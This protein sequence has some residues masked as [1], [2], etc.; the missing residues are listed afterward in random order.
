MNCSSLGFDQGT[1][2]LT[3][4]GDGSVCGDI[5]NAIRCFGDNLLQAFADL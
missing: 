4:L 5:V 3:D 1:D 2:L